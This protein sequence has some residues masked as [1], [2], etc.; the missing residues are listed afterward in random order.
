MAVSDQSLRRPAQLSKRHL[1]AFL[2]LLRKSQAARI[3][4]VTSGAGQLTDSGTWAPA[5]S[6]SKTALNGVTGQFAAVLKDE[7]IAVNASMIFRPAAPF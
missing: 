6:I 3:I 5:D 2:P 7:N 1:S 4:N